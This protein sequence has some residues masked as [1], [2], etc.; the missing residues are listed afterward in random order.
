LL[1]VLDQLHLTRL[2]GLVQL[3][4]QFHHLD[5]SAQLEAVSRRREKEAQEGAKPVEP[6]AFIPTMKK[7]GGDTAAEMNQAFMKSTNQEPWHTLNYSDEDVCTTTSEAESSTNPV[8]QSTEAYNAYSERL[9]LPDV[10]EAPKLHSNVNNNQFL[11]AISAPSASK[12]AKKRSTRKAADEL[13]EIS[14]ESD[15]EDTEGVAPIV[16]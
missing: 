8:M 13:I 14:D 10:A 11:D 6:K 7:S 16:S 2:N 3:R 12:G 4:T 1:I 9:F 15:E 5:A